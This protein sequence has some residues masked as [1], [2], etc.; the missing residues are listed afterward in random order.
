MPVPWLLVAGVLL[1]ALGAYLISRALGEV[2]R[3]LD[4]VLVFI[5]MTGNTLGF[6]LFAGILIEVKVIPRDPWW[7]SSIAVLVCVSL[8]ILLTFLGAC[9]SQKRWKEKFR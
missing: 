1:A 8:G 5:A 3:V 2:D 9:Y 4:R 6:L 7:A